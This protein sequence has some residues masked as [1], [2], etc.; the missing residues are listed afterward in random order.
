MGRAGAR[1]RSW[2]SRFASVCGPGNVPGTL[3]WPTSLAGWPLRR[4]CFPREREIGPRKTSGHSRYSARLWPTVRARDRG[5]YLTTSG[6]VCSDPD[7]KS[8]CRVSA[9]LALRIHRKLVR[10]PRKLSVLSV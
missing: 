6:E 5:A 9:R 8:A 3:G 1:R 10:D 2:R 4:S 7:S